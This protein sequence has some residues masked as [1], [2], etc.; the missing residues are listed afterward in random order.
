MGKISE[1]T[2][3]KGKT[4]KAGDRE[5]WLR[6]EYSVKAL[7]EDDEVQVAKATIEGV[8]D[9]WLS[10]VTLP[11]PQVQQQAPTQ[12]GAQ[13]K[14]RTAEEVK[15]AIPEDLLGLLRVEEGAEYIVLTPRQ[16]LGSEIFSRVMEC[17]E[18]LG[19]QYVSAGR[20]SHFRIKR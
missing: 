10:N 4:V 9:G 3:T 20:G 12:P 18:P 7:V 8:I 2:V 15:K 6:L 16:F 14:K 11:K 5:E 19:G 1:I 17:I 13:P